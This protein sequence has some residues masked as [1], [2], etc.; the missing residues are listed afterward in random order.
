MTTPKARS[1]I[2]YEFDGKPASGQAKNIGDGAHWL[3]MPLPFALNHINLWLFRDG[4]GWAIVDTGLGDDASRGHWHELFDSTLD[5]APVRRV[6]VTHLH[7]DHVGCAGFLA[8]HFDAP[9][10]MTREE[11]LLC[12]VLVADTGREV[13][14]EGVAFYRSAGYPESALARYRKMFG[15]F[16]RFVTPLPES[17]QRMQDG[18][19]LHIDGSAWE[20]V[21]GRGHSPEHACLYNA[22]QNLFVGGDQLLPAISAN[23][24][25]YPTEPS[26]NPLADWLESLAAIRKRIP[27]DVLVLPAHGQPYRGAHARIDEL[28]SHH[29]VRLDAL[30]DRCSEPQRAVDVFPA[31]YHRDI[32]EENLMFATGEAIAHLNYL[33][34][35]GDIASEPDMNGV[36]WYRRT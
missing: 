6:I 28:T 7:P 18:A 14:A 22:E 9:L 12:R 35:R 10:F 1:D 29:E 15:Y 5:N 11:Y 21:I 8:R 31:L 32:T 24:S 34:A 17:Y 36:T 30:L 23:V 19:R 4:S 20:V 26:A 13:P 2:R 33:M 25:V 3:R 16:G 27:A